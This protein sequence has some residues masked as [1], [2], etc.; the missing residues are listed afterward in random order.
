MTEIM[1]SLVAMDTV[2]AELAAAS[3]IGAASV[4]DFFERCAGRGRPW[5]HVANWGDLDDIEVYRH[6]TLA[7]KPQGP[8]YGVSEAC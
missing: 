1:Y 7:E 6:L 3:P 2:L 8:L 4:A 5:K